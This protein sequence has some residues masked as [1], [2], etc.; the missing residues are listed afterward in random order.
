M[1][2]KKHIQISRRLSG[3]TLFLTWFAVFA[4]PVVLLQF[5]LEYLF[6]LTLQANQQAA[7]EILIGEMSSFKHDLEAEA[8]IE[9]RLKAFFSSHNKSES[10]AKA[11]MH[12]LSLKTGLK[13][14]GVVILYGGKMAVDIELDPS[15]QQKMPTLPRVLMRRY[16]AS[17]AFRHDFPS[18]SP[19]VNPS[20]CEISDDRTQKDADSFFRRQFGLIAE[21]PLQPNKLCR[22]IS[23]KLD[24]SA[25]FYFQVFTTS[26]SKRMKGG[27][28][29]IMRGCDLNQ[30]QIWQE[31][32]NMSTSG[33]RRSYT[34]MATPL[35]GKNKLTR[36]IITRF[37]SDEAGY[38]LISTP[39]DHAL[40]DLIQSGTFSLRHLKPVLKKL[41][42]LK[43]TI[44]KSDLHHPLVAWTGA[45]YFSARLFSLLG[46][47][48]FLRLYFYGIDFQ[49]GIRGKVLIGTATML[50]LPVTLLLAGFATWSQFSRIYAWYQAE[51]LQQQYFNELYD[52][53]GN[54]LTQLQQHSIGTAAKVDKA[55][56]SNEKAIPL[57]LEAGLS[58]SSASDLYLDRST[59][60][61]LHIKSPDHHL[62]SSHK[63]ESA[64]RLVFDTILNAYDRQGNFIEAIPEE[65]NKGVTS[66]DEVSI[67]KMINSWARPFKMQ[68]INSNNRFSTV[69]V[70]NDDKFSPYALLSFKYFDST[71]VREFISRHFRPSPRFSQISAR[72]F[73]AESNKAGYQLRSLN[74]GQPL[75]NQSLL[76]K[77]RIAEWGENFTWRE[78]TKKLMQ[79]RWLNDYPLVVLIESEVFPGNL[80][81]YR[82]PAL[83]F[84]YGLLLLL[85]IYLFFELIYL[86]PIREFIRVTIGVGKG[87]YTEQVHLQANDEFAD[88]QK[89]FTK[90]IQGLEQRRKL[91]QFVSQDVKTAVEGSD[92]AMAPGGERVAATVVFIQLQTDKSFENCNADSQLAQLSRFISSG[93]LIIEKYGGVIDKLIEETM[94]LVFRKNSAGDNHSLRACRATLQIVADLRSCGMTIRAGIASGNVV[95][96]RIGSR[97]GKLDYTVIGD[98]VNM[99]ARLKSSPVRTCVTG[100]IIAPST[101]RNLRGSARVSFLERTAIKGKSRQYPL[102]E[103][104]EI[105]Q[106]S[107]S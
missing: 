63:E 64:R 66:A 106:T 31:T 34:R 86:Q 35:D 4:V 91:A 2:E 5:S 41:P 69:F 92:D 47:V 42:L 54:Y 95:S 15:L 6:E 21:I 16:L 12:K 27:C 22:T 101:I 10:N 59:G 105:R 49:L 3:T 13:V 94:M 44:P 75:Q 43:V 80:S 76:E 62:P 99:A 87:N 39:P 9:R 68:R 85:F 28:L 50:L 1:A 11:L 7:A 98:A 20:G 36:E 17:N 26:D 96:G 56:K 51:E 8:F 52:G 32:A 70:H 77:I 55:R 97:L 79:T 18:S 38:H 84:S 89:V 45:I 72:F 67:N 23:A 48:F 73:L 37:I 40:I 65:Q 100:I 53:F 58:D 102:Y 14:A 57:I 19:T 33:A 81:V 82:I 71:L 29:L 93:D 60:P 103:L 104:I 25:F 74:D 107:N 24:G 30:R 78:R 61:S 90:M 88:L 46:A 83:L